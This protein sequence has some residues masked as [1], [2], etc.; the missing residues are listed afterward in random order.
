MF[1]QKVPKLYFQSQFSMSK[2]EGI[3]SK[4]LGDQFCKKHFFLTSIFEPLYFLKSCP[5]FDELVLPVFSKYNGFLSACRFLGKKLAFKDPPSLKFHN[6]T[7]TNNYVTVCFCASRKF[8]FHI[9]CD[10]ESASRSTTCTHLA[11]GAFH[12]SAKPMK[13]NIAFFL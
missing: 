12:R 1:S 2:I 3:F 4:K 8:I 5:I 9:G 11:A 10:Q 13:L 7:D 6:R